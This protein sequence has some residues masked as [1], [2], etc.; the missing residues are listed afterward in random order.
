M[1]VSSPSGAVMEQTTVQHLLAMTPALIVCRPG[2]P[3]SCHRDARGAQHQ[4]DWQS[5]GHHHPPARHPHLRGGGSMLHPWQ[6]NCKPRARGMLPVCC[7]S[8]VLLVR[9]G[10]GLSCCKCQTAPPYRST[11]HGCVT[12]AMPD[13][14]CHEAQLL[15]TVR[16]SESGCLSCCVPMRWLCRCLTSSCS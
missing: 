16:I 2:C 15:F 14:C 5:H 3:C 9:A 12:S 11:S 10:R 8:C 1:L 7:C 13:V 6:C 4:P